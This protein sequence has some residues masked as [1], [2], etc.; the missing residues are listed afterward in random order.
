MKCNTVFTENNGRNPIVS[1]IPT[2]HQRNLFL[3]KILVGFYWEGHS[4]NHV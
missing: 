1:V 4:F 2:F 3:S